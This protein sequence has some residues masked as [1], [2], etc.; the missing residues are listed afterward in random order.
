MW[1]IYIIMSTEENLQRIADLSEYAASKCSE[2]EDYSIEMEANLARLQ[3]T[4]TSIRILLIT[5]PISLLIGLLLGL[6]I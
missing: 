4:Y 5:I 6:L 1:K 2:L 3:R